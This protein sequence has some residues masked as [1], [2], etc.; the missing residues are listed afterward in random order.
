ML[1]PGDLVAEHD[2]SAN[3]TDYLALAVP[4]SDWV[5]AGC[6]TLTQAPNVRR[7]TGNFGAGVVVT[8]Q[9]WYRASKNVEAAFW[10]LHPPQ[11]T[12]WLWCMQTSKGQHVL[13]RAAVNR[14][15]KAFRIQ[16]G[17]ESLLVRHPVLLE[18]LDATREW[19][20]ISGKSLPYFWTIDADAKTLQRRGQPVHAVTETAIARVVTDATL[21]EL[22][23]VA[24][25]AYA[26]MRAGVL[27]DFEHP[28]PLPHPLL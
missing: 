18:L 26:G 5:C 24:K 11:D 1:A 27:P 16:Q 4:A 17:T 12:D 2:I 21:G 23:A 20:R 13:W 3:F 28:D 19:Q 15:H 14:H 9:A 8:R 22:W 7:I 6:A 25:I 10:A